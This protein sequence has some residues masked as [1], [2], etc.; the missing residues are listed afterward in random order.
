MKTRFTYFALLSGFLIGHAAGQTDPKADRESLPQIAKEFDI[1]YFAREPL[2]RNP[3]SIA[4]DERGRMFV[5]HGP[6]YRN[7]KPSTP[8]D[9]VVILDD[10]N[11]DGVAD[12]A[13]TFATGFNC[14]QGLAWHGKDLWV[15]NAPDLTV[16]RDTDGDDVADE[17]IRVFTDLGNIEHALHGL[18]WAPDGRLYMSKGN[19]KGLV[20]KDWKKD[21][22]DRVAPKPFRDLWGVPGPKDAP[23]FPAPKT[24]TRQTYKSTYHD[25]EDDW[26]RSGGILRCEDM[27]RNLEIVARGL[28]NPYGLGFDA[29]F[30]WLS[31][32]QDQSDGDR[33]FMPFFSA[34]FGWSHAWS[35]HWT[36][37]NH[38]PTVPISAPVF[39]GSGTGVLFANA[40]NWPDAYRGMWLINDWLFKKTQLYRPTW[41]GALMLPQG[42]QWED[43]ITAGKSL[44]RP[45]DMAFGPEGALY[46]IG[47]SSGYGVERDK[48]GNMTNEGRVF[49]VM[50]KGAA[51]LPALSVKKMPDMTVAE[52]IAEFSGLLPVR[53]INAQDELVR[54]GAAVAGEIVAALK[55]PTLPTAGETWAVWTLARIG[56]SE[57]VLKRTA[58]DG[59]ASLN[60][61]IQAVRALGLVKSAALPQLLPAL[62][63][64]SEPRLRLAA[65]QSAHQAGAK[66]SLATLTNHAATESERVCYY[67]TWRALRDLGGESGLRLLLA[68][69]RGPVRAAALLGL[70]D[71][72]AM[73][74]DALNP[75][76]DDSDQTVA[77]VAQLGLGRGVMKQRGEVFKGGAAAAQAARDGAAGAKPKPEDATP[78]S[79]LASNIKA[80]S[81]RP[82]SSGLLQIGQPSYT[83][84]AYAFT[85]VPE[86]IAGAEI[87]RTS[88]EDDGSRGQSFLT[89]DLAL[90]STVFVAH[91]VRVKQ[92]PEWL[93]GFAD[94]GITVATSDTQ[95]QLWSKDFPA[96]NVALGGNIPATSSG[97]KANY[98]VAIQ[99]KPLT[100]P[101][102]PTTEEPSQAALAKA[103]VRRGEALFFHSAACATCH[104]VGNRGINFGPDLTNLGARMD[105]KYVVQ[106]ILEP[107]AVITEG[108][109]AHSIDADGENYTG[110]L[111]SSGRIVRLGVGGGKVVEI[112]EEKITKHKT[113]PVSPMPAMGSV[114]TAQDVA[115]IAKWLLTTEQKVAAAPP[116][117]PAPSAPVPSATA[118]PADTSPLSIVQKADRL[119]IMQ[120]GAM[121]GEFVF[122]DAKTRRPFFANLRAPGGIPV[123]RT[124]PPVAG[125]DATDH[126][127]MHP[128]VW[129]GFGKISGQDFWRNKATIKHE[130]FVVPPAWKD[131]RLEFSSQSSLLAADGSKMAAMR[132]DFTLAPKGHELHLT[133]AA[134]I[135][136]EMDG[137]YFGDEEEMG[138]GVRM[139]TPLTEKASGVITSSTGKT[140]AKATWGQPA[141]WCDYSGTINGIKVG[142]KVI[143]DPANFRS[144]WW[145][146]RDYGVFVANPF[147][148]AAMKQGEPSRVEVKRGETHRL[149]FTVVFYSTKR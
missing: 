93:Q 146:N 103:D 70:L 24:F 51:K 36:G 53:R 109:A 134:A 22:P 89:F 139:A 31:V 28:R 117:A 64:S 15:A 62:L 95:F 82:Y 88:N 59:A 49:R 106:S 111:L 29:G 127:D 136:P 108:F 16:V 121:I 138:L 39:H 99:P 104:R 4:F 148:R 76:A 13:R 5:S 73:K 42:G 116:S 90:A 118:N 50:P 114:L 92:R 105:P 61:R 149:K 133:W 87:I 145:H 60:R 9:S 35:P 135:R 78:V 26:G 44:F 30:D 140:T 120:S 128:G 67:A 3:C 14:I 52:L 141:E 71:L 6:Q 55:K 131:G 63:A 57:D 129:V 75:L 143:P 101:A 86:T 119:V 58:T 47:W 110:V 113:L 7:P 94:A 130:S 54:R 137:F 12:K 112:P 96:V 115:D 23:D 80:E 142:I 11:G 46:I 69:K 91:D 1:A 144:S 27:G 33:L 72:R 38:L 34:E 102:A 122:N 77:T 43:F 19:S 25:P 65:I 98:F 97:P 21:E 84:R 8:P 2:V 126:A 81:K 100:P 37:E 56:G 125:V 107:N 45:V 68:D 132:C 79:P 74:P 17:Y 20:I 32:D 10:T 41:Q 48:D 40:P 83:D 123:T 66:D 85:R 147:G 124:W 18:N